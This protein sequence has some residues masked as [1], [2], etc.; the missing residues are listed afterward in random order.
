[1]N[2]RRDAGRG[3]AGIGRVMGGEWRVFNVCRVDGERIAAELDELDRPISS[4]TVST[5]T[6]V[7]KR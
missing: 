1:M 6:S 2:G 5:I 3:M 4:A 7:W